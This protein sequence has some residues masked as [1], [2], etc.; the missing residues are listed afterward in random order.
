MSIDTYLYGQGRV[1][2]AVRDPVTGVPGKYRFI[3]DVSALSIKLATT[4]V[5][6]KESFD[7]QRA[8]VRS[9][10]I[11]KSATLDM[12]MHQIDADN[13]AL[14][15]YGAKQATISGTVTGEA[16]PTDLAA[17][18]SVFLANPGVSTVIVKDSAGV[19]ATLVAGT[20]YALNPDSGRIDI[21][22]VGTYV[23]PFKVDYAYKAR[24]AVGMFTTGQQN[25]ALKYEG[26]NLAEN[27]ASVL[28]DLYKV[29]PDPLQELA[30]IT[31]GNDVAG[32]QVTGGIL[33]DSS[34]AATGALGQFGA[35]T[36]LGS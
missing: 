6:H 34:K 8:L 10:P 13:L 25:I 33:L 22:N 15:F 29:A 11:D 36:T 26:I 19:P 23:Q 30:L 16:L 4:K 3:G 24:T 18:D 32:M 14:V 2:I 7:G 27:N 17:G 9:F 5:E 35:I 20:D 1:S 12:T 21:L 31:T 28:V